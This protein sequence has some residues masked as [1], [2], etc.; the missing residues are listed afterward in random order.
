MPQAIYPNYLIKAIRSKLIR[1]LESKNILLAHLY[2]KTPLDVDQLV[3][4]VQKQAAFIQP[5][6]CNTTKLLQEALSKGQSVLVEGQ[7]GALRDPDHGIYPYTTSSS[8]LAGYAAV[9]AGVP[10]YAIEKV[11]AVTKAYS[12]CVG[13]GPFVTEIH[14]EDAYELR[15]RGGDAGNKFTTQNFNIPVN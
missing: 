3:D 10:P 15:K 12:S 13:E 1:A 14:A 6:V 5:F 9:G 4:E 11:V 8:T 2:K 7:L